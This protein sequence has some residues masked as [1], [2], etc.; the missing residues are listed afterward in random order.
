ML[1]DVI[2]VFVFEE[3]FGVKNAYDIKTLSYNSIGN[4]VVILE[5][6]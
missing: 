2:R 5:N 4:R 1:V 6:A 3:M